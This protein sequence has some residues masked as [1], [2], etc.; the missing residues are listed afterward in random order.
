MSSLPIHPALEAAAT[1]EYTQKG[2]KMLIDD[3]SFEYIKKDEK[4]GV[5][6]LIG[7]ALPKEK[8]FEDITQGYKRVFVRLAWRI[9]MQSGPQQ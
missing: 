4:A 3:K 2:N 7:Y 5:I 6:L 9:L 8:A 1:I